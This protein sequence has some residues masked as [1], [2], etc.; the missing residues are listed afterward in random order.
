MDTK[1]EI[2][3]NKFYEWLPLTNIF[4]IFFFNVGIKQKKAVK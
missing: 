2:S 4:V 1:A 3:A